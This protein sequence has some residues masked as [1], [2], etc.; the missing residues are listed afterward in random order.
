MVVAYTIGQPCHV[1][2]WSVLCAEKRPS[3]FPE[4]R[5]FT[6]PLHLSCYLPLTTTVISA[7]TTSP[8]NNL[9][10]QPIK[11]T[12]LPH[13]CGWYRR[14]TQVRISATTT[15]F[16]LITCPTRTSFLK[17]NSLA[18]P[19]FPPHFH[20][21]QRLSPTR[22]GTVTTAVDS[23]ESKLTSLRSVFSHRQL[24]KTKSFS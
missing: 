12:V 24:K 17:M 19:P 18:T 20:E 14:T 1:V 13:S 15:L 22:S 10:L 9:L 5:G 21:Q 2:M 11:S 16:G 4:D 3:C 23:R 6:D 8:L 7:S